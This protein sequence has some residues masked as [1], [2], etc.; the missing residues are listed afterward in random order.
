MYSPDVT[1][2][3]T[4]A[5]WS[6]QRCDCMTSHVNG[7]SLSVLIVDDNRDAAD[8]LSVLLR[9][10]GHDTH[11]AYGGPDAMAIVR[12]W[13]PDVAFLD[14]VM[15]RVGGVELA[16]WMRDQTARPISLVALTGLRT[17]DEVALIKAGAFDHVLFKPVDPDELLGFL[18]ARAGHSR[19]SVPPVPLT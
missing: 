8:A 19:D 14:V 3:A 7:R 12:G 18:D 2:R 11:F 16:A 9:L 5:A 15:D 4:D 1:R 13:H 10:N 6:N 17:N